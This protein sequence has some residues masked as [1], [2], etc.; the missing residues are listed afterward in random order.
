MRKK[1][2]AAAVGTTAVASILLGAGL[3]MAATSGTFNLAVSGAS[4][5]GS[6]YYDVHPSGTSYTGTGIQYV[7][8]LRNTGT[9][10]AQSAYF[11]AQ[12][13]GYGYS[14]LAKAAPRTNASFNRV[15]Y[16]GAARYVRYSKA[17]VCRD[18]TVLGQ[19]CQ[20]GTYNR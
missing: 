20:V 5:S 13:E 7:G 12:V 1:S 16:D 2:R 3:A 17:Q 11:Y 14:Q 4:A 8:T 15:L 19:S 18:R 9:T 10:D 6:Y